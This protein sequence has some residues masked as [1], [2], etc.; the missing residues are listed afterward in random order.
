MELTALERPFLFFPLKDHFEQ[1]DCVDFRLKRYEAGIRMDFDDTTSSRLAGA[2]AIH[3][4]SPVKYKPVNTNGAEK[5]ASMII[6]LIQ[7]ERSL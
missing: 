2:V 3:I 5:A 4:G 7:K 1:Q 6:D